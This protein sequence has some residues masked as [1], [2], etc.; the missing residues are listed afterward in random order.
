M[1]LSITRIVIFSGRN[2]I[3]DIVKMIMR[4]TEDEEKH[5]EGEYEKP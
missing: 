3:R 5:C 4:N 1:S 2:K